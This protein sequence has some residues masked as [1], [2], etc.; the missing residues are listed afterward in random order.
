MLQRESHQEGSIHWKNNKPTLRYMLKMG[1]RWVFKR[2]TLPEWVVTEKQANQYRQER[3][4]E[5]NRL[6]NGSEQEVVLTLGEFIKQRWPWYLKKR[7]VK[8]ST[9]YTYASMFKCH[10]M[11]AFGSRE[12][13]AITPDDLSVFFEKLDERVSKKY[14]RNLYG[15]L[16]LVFKYAVDLELITKSPLRATLHKPARRPRPKKPALSFGEVRSILAQLPGEYELLFLTAAITGLR[17][18]EL[19]GLRWRDFD[20]AG[21]TLRIA[22][23]VWRMTLVTPKTE[24]SVR[25]I[26]V[27]P[28]L[29][30]RLEAHRQASHLGERVRSLLQGIDLSYL[31]VCQQASRLDAQRR[32]NHRRDRMTGFRISN[33]LQ[34]QT[35]GRY[36]IGLLLF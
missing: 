31:P 11:P 17:A 7:E 36:T 18:G 24:A 25:T 27:P 2:E 8:P 3:M 12:L 10:I 5:I 21:R 9:A 29:S 6:N 35:R 30:E 1:E 20:A 16:N 22:S 14:W 19:L 15:L 33:R 34:L 23:N 26:H 32:G 28:P 4:V 13:E